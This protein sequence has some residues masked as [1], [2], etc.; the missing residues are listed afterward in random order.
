MNCV[1][2]DAGVVLT[3]TVE[4]DGGHDRTDRRQFVK[5]IDRLAK[6]GDL[7]WVVIRVVSGHRPQDV[8]GRVYQALVRRGYRPNRR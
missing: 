8:I 7:G 1:E 3:H 4:Y 2:L 6:I 5:D